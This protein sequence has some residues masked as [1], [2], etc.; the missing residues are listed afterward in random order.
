M[1]NVTELIDRYVAVWNE[2]NAELPRRGFTALWAEDG[3]CIDLCTEA[4][5]HDAIETTI[6]KAYEKFVAKGLVFK[7]ASDADSHHDIVKFN[8]KLMQANDRK[9]AAI[10]LSTRS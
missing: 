5:G 9:V 2:P 3:A 1:S 6:A 8:W 10:G 7:T 4:R